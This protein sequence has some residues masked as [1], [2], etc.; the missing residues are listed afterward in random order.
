MNIYKS[1]NLALTLAKIQQCQKAFISSANNEVNFMLKPQINKNFIDFFYLLKPN[2][3]FIFDIDGVLL[4][5]KQLLPRTK[6]CINLLT[7]EDG[8]FKV[9][10]IFLTNAG[11]ELKSSKST[12]LSNL[13]GVKVRSLFIYWSEF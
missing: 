8:K 1:K 2:Y 6:A 13:L 7:K 3:G 4:R 5:G 12:K 9:P 11:N 10:T